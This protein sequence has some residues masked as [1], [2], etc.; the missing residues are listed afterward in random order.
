MRAAVHFDEEP[1]PA[2]ADGNG[3]GVGRRHARRRFESTGQPVT[4]V[5]F[6]PDG[7]QLAST[8]YSNR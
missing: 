2:A 5:A 8:R 6:S 4:S 3:N 7:Q 1:S